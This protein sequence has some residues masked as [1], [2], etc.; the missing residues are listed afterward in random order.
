MLLTILLSTLSFNLKAQEIND[1]VVCSGMVIGNANIDYLI[2]NEQASYDAYRIAYS[3]EFASTKNISGSSE[4]FTLRRESIMEVINSYNNGNYDANLY[5][6]VVSCYRLLAAVLLKPEIQKY[7]MT[8]EGA[9]ETKTVA[10]Q[11]FE[12]LKNQYK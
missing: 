7:L 3:A 11:A 6:A 12:Q 4:R 10:Q 1:I 9:Q 2:G 5:E 8:S